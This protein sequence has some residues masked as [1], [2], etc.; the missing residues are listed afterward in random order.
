MNPNAEH[1]LD[2][3]H[4]TMRLTV[5][6]QIAKGL[7]PPGFEPREHALKQLERIKWFLRY[8]NVFRA[9]QTVSW[10]QMDI[11]ADEPTERHKKLL[12]KLDEFDTY[13][14]NNAGLIPNYGER[15]RGLIGS[16]LHRAE[17]AVAGAPVAQ[18]QED[19]HVLGEAFEQVG[20]LRLLA[21]RVQAAL[22]EETTGLFVRRS[23]GQP[24]LELGR[25]ALGL[26][27]RGHGHA[28]SNQ[29]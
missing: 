13:I 20:T 24:A 25:F 19:G 7:G 21:D 12:D 5:M 8:G 4:I 2:W 28:R 9:L 15:F 11:D 26:D 23:A 3:F 10:L 6:R 29:I 17:S 18:N 1:I 27:G 16:V 14:R 22:A